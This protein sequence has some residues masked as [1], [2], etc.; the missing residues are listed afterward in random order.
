[1]TDVWT[2][3]AEERTAI[4]DGLSKLAEEDW[5]KPSLCAGW[6]VQD[7]VG[8]MIATAHMTPGLF[9]K[10]F[11]KSRFNFDRMVQ[12]DIARYTANKTPAMLLVAYGNRRLSRTHP[13]G[14]AMAMV[15]ECVV[16]SEDIF[17]ALGPYGEHDPEHLVATANFYEKNNLLVPAKKRIA[18]LS[19][20]STDVAWQSSATGP[21]VSGPL[22]ALIMAM[23]GRKAAL[24]D[25]SGDGLETLRGRL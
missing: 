3:I 15:G 21:E 19:L 16:H 13:P 10:E 24:E 23:A 7:V 2:M 11:A 8:H 14:P 17:R 25:L 6:V 5:R 20:R 4:Y 9:F 18:G 12:K 1:M 22:V